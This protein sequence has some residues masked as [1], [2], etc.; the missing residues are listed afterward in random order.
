MRT[1]ELFWLFLLPGVATAPMAIA[2]LIRATPLRVGGAVAVMGLS[3]AG[4][5]LQSPEVAASDLAAYLAVFVLPSLAGLLF[6]LSTLAV[7]YRH[8][9]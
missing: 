4:G 5:L 1:S 6:L 3:T 8:G 9:V 2:L 7:R